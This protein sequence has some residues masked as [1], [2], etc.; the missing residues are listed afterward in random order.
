MIQNIKPSYTEKGNDPDSWDYGSHDLQVQFEFL[1]KAD[2]LCEFLRCFV[3]VNLPSGVT[4]YCNEMEVFDVYLEKGEITEC[5]ISAGLIHESFLNGFQMEDLKVTINVNAYGKESKKLGSWDCPGA[6]ESLVVDE[7]FTLGD[8]ARIDGITIHRMND[9]EYKQLEFDSHAQ[10][11]LK[12]LTDSQIPWGEIKMKLIDKRG[13]TIGETE[14]GKPIPRSGLL[15]H[16]PDF[17][18]VNVGKA[19]GA[20]IEVFASC[21]MKHLGEFSE[22]SNPVLNV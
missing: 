2:V 12:N 10:V 13:D 11:V 22:E 3:S 14:F 4:L 20:V 8:Y 16:Q 15:G 21:C 17:Y 7:K 19:K 5:G 18:D 6:N 9:N 1:N